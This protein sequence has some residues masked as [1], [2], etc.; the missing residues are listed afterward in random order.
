MPTLLV[1]TP[2]PEQF[3][4]QIGPE[5]IILSVSVHRM[6]ERLYTEMPVETAD[7]LVMGRM[8]DFVVTTSEGERYP[9][10]PAVFWG[11]YQIIGSAGN[12]LICRRLIHARSAWPVVSDSAEFDY[13][14]GR[15]RVAA[16]RGAWIYRSDE[17][18]YGL[19]NASAKGR[20]HVIAGEAAEI[21]GV[22]WDSR[23]GRLSLLLSVLPPVLTF[24]ALLAYGATLRHEYALASTLLFS[25]GLLLLSGI[26]FSAWAS[27]GRWH[28]KAA[29]VSGAEYARMFQIL[30]RMLGQR[31]SE[32]FPGMAL[33]RAAQEDE[34]NSLAVPPKD[35]RDLKDRLYDAFDR[36]QSSVARA[37]G[38]ERLAQLGTWISVAI[39]LFCVVHAAL[40][41]SG[42]SEFLT[43]WLP[44]A[45][46]AFHASIWRHK[47]DRAV[48]EGREF[49]GELEFV[50]RELL[51][52]VP[53]E[54]V[55]LQDQRTADAL[56]ATLKVL[57]RSVAE[58][59]QRRLSVSMGSNPPIPL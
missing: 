30:V 21:N 24:L 3:H 20:A 57:C 43:I 14:P 5:L 23:Y 38:A 25:E 17:D 6:V 22:E 32:R 15:G 59:T 47:L 41:H 44:S 4:G 53:G 7:G 18:D 31:P 16:P 51:A 29:V 10:P 28:L 52:L 2:P 9:I 36:V 19:I 55:D 54:V 49:L 27:R 35:W 37:H 58:F 40:T 11:T 42:L 26:A 45:I 56:R 33:W 34:T 12:K 50:R 8:G 39:I 1:D 46:A 48:A 13:G